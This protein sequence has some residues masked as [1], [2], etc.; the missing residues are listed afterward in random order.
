VKAWPLVT[1]LEDA[2]AR[3]RE[4]VLAFPPRTRRALLRVT[5]APQEQRAEAI[6]R[7]Y[8]EPH[9]RETAEL[10]IDLEEDR[11]TALIVRPKRP[12]TSSPA[13]APRARSCHR[14]SLKR[15]PERLPLE[16]VS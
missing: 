11:R 13:G 16:I 12:C 14:L 15:R 4:A 6:G 5:T 9:G 10:L 3:I 1:D 8:R 2:E 7:L